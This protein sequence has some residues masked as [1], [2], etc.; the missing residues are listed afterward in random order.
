MP[1]YRIS[2]KLHENGMT[3]DLVM[4]YG[5][6]SMKGKLVNL[7]LFDS[8]PAD[9]QFRVGDATF[10]GEPVSEKRPA[11]WMFRHAGAQLSCSYSA[12]IAQC[13]PEKK[14]LLI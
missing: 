8:S 9:L 14:K 5:D 7:S 13:Q 10:L 2:F 1:E 12:S 3:R 11:A 6:F 4:D